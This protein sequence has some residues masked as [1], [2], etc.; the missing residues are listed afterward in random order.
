MNTVMPWVQLRPPRSRNHTASAAVMLGTDALSRAKATK[1][2]LSRSTISR[3]FRIASR[4]I[5]PLPQTQPRT[6]PVLTTMKIGFLLFVASSRASVS[7]YFQGIVVHGWFLT[8]K[9]TF[10]SSNSARLSPVADFAVGLLL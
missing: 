7:E 3:S 6:L 9:D 5:S 8:F 2:F 4:A 1:C 10:T